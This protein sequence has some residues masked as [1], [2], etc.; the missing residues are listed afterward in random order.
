MN[1]QIFEIMVKYAF[2]QAHKETYMKNK[3]SNNNYM[4]DSMNNN[5]SWALMEI[6]KMYL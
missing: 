2:M 3:V 5:L 4:N 1:I 6:C